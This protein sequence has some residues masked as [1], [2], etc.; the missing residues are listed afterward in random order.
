MKNTIWYFI[1]FMSTMFSETLLFENFN[2]GSLPSGWSFTPDPSDYPSNSGTWQINNWNT[3]YNNSAP[4]ATYYWSPASPSGYANYSG[5]YMYSEEINVSDTT[6][7]LVRFKIALDGF[8]TPTGHYNGMRVA[9]KS[10]DQDWTTV[11]SYQI[12]AESG[13]TVDINPRVETFYARMGQT[14]QLGGRHLELILI[15]LMRGTLMILK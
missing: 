4:A 6:N 15:I 8:P 9:Y 7:V 3:D 10:D 11:L 12:S 5:H 2:S 14:L 1:F 13:A